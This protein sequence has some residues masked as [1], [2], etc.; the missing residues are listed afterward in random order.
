MLTLRN[1]FDNRPGKSDIAIPLLQLSSKPQKLG[2]EVRHGPV[3]FNKP[4]DQ[5]APAH[6][7]FYETLDLWSQSK[8][9]YFVL[10]QDANL[11]GARFSVS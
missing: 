3:L 8:A 1:K 11:C 5:T 6:T 2:L 10:A 9:L 7:T 4:M